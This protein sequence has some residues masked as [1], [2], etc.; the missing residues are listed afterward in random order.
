M[1]LYNVIPAR[2]GIMP[3][4]RTFP[5]LSTPYL[6]V[7]KASPGCLE[8]GSPNY[9]SGHNE[10][11]PLPA[12]NQFS[13]LECSDSGDDLDYHLSTT[14][15]APAQASPDG[16]GFSPSYGM[17]FTSTPIKQNSSPTSSVNQ[18]SKLKVLCI[19]CQSIQSAEKRARFYALLELYKA[20]IAEGTELWLHKDILDSEVFPSSLGYNLPIRRDRSTASKGDGVFILV[21]QRLVVSE[22][23][24]LST[25]CE[26]VWAKVEIVGTKPLLIAAYY[27]PSEHDQISA[28]EL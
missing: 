2:S 14:Q 11:H 26:I 17:P 27:R 22:Q 25:N 8:C 28:E 23:P 3:T 4:V 7:L 20:D 15:N 16:N 12:S 18:F 13:L 10:L 1:Q 21:S 24:Q 19:K 6:P 9:S 5:L